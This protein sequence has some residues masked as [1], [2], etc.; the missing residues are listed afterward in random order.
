MRI[1]TGASDN[2]SGWLINMFWGLNNLLAMSGIVRSAFWKP[3]DESA[4]ESS[5]AGNLSKLQT[6]I[7]HDARPEP[8][9]AGEP[10]RRRK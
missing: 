7:A 9:G 1:W 4:S 5:V 3:A 6:A 10:V 2:L 8:V